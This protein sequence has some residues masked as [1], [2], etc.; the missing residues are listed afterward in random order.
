[1]SASSS[2]LK[3]GSAM[4]IHTDGAD[5]EVLTLAKE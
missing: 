3:L 5:T 1:M 4:L 2:A